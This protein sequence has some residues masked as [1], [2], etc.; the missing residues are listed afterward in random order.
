MTSRRHTVCRAAEL[1]SGHL[2][3]AVLERA[4]IFLERLPDGTVKAF[5]TR[6]PHQGADLS[7][8]CTTG[9]AS[10]SDPHSVHLVREGEILRCPW[11]GFEFDMVS[12]C[13]LV[14]PSRL[15]L[16]EYPVVIDGG[17]VIVEA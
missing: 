15:R 14:Q 4:T 16:R 3:R 8:G 10:G 9:V 13:A 6:C 17:D 2:K 1:E 12:G 7:H 11:H 5:S